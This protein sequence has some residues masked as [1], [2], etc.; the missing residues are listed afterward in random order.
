MDPNAPP[1]LDDGII[2]L[3]NEIKQHPQAEAEVNI[4][5][6][7]QGQVIIHDKFGPPKPLRIEVSEGPFRAHGGGGHRVPSPLQ[8]QLFPEDIADIDNDVPGLMRGDSWDH[9]KDPGSPTDTKNLPSTV[10][11]S[12][13]CSGSPSENSRQRSSTHRPKS[14]GDEKG[15]NPP[16]YGRRA[17]KEEIWA[18]KRRRSR[19][20]AARKGRA[21][22]QYN[23]QR[24]E[25]PRTKF[26]IKKVTPWEL[27]SESTDTGDGRMKSKAPNSKNDEHIQIEIIGTR[28][29]PSHERQEMDGS[30]TERK[31]I[32]GPGKL[33]DMRSRLRALFGSDHESQSSAEDEP[34]QPSG[35]GEL[36]VPEV[37]EPA[38]RR[39]DKEKAR[40]QEKPTIVVPECEECQNP[41]P[42][43]LSSGRPASL[44]EPKSARSFQEWQAGVPFKPLSREPS[45]NQ[46]GQ[47]EVLPCGHPRVKLSPL[48]GDPV[49][50]NVAAR[51]TNGGRSLGASR[52]PSI[53]TIQ[54]SVPKTAPRITAPPAP[55]R[56]TTKKPVLVG[57]DSSS[58]ISDREVLKGLGIVMEGVVNED[59]QAWIK[60]ATG[61]NVRRFLGDLAALDKLGTGQLAD[62]AR[63][64]TS[65]RQ[66]AMERLGS[67]RGHKKGRSE[68]SVL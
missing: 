47:D 23:E 10:D 12:S 44:N 65:K 40:V 21:Q 37:T 24:N 28:A 67:V 59:V 8:T 29:E 42:G 35:S 61:T 54:E 41:L 43:V 68:G 32:F 11:F 19:E 22:G 18:E 38:K 17:S 52:A 49:K 25:M 53:F 1:G 64:N 63:R 56:T 30:T 20:E 50:R 9:K 3:E 6:Q 4:I 66:K 62:K 16:I 36:K 51:R 7:S 46:H 13:F 39:Q 60:E 31:G 33:K 2:M 57:S 48:T 27:G 55:F 5:P 14:A 34:S 15:M 58:D 45:I 26:E